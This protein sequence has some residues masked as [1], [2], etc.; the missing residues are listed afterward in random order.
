MSSQ[1]YPSKEYKR[2][3]ELMNTYFH[4]EEFGSI[5]IDIYYTN[6]YDYMYCRGAAYNIRNKVRSVPKEESQGDN[7]SFDH[8]IFIGEYDSRLGSSNRKKIE[9]IFPKKTSKYVLEEYLFLCFIYKTIRFDNSYRF[10]KDINR[11]KRFFK[12]R[13]ENVDK[14]LYYINSDDIEH[15]LSV[16]KKEV[17]RI[18]NE[19]TQGLKLDIDERTQTQIND[20]LRTFLS[21]TDSSSTETDYGSA[22]E[23]IR[24]VMDNSRNNENMNAKKDILSKLMVIIPKAD[25]ELRQVTNNHRNS[26]E[27][28]FNSRID[29]EH[30][31][32]ILEEHEAAL[33]KKV[34]PEIIRANV[35]IDIYAIFK[36]LPSEYHRF[37]RT[38]A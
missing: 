1:I 7:L 22:S 37:C 29:L 28:Q 33:D 21:N 15:Y 19:G 26:S 12:G 31:I 24:E 5:N 13:F 2:F 9:S 17:E 23:I 27:I 35:I 36:I 16:I 30:A 34:T 18:L 38:Y 32:R 14:I 6:K 8:Y 3:N 25:A 20:C 4:L 10:Q 11:F